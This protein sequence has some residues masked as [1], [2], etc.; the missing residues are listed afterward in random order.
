MLIDVLIA[1][2][3]AL[4]PRNEAE[5][6]AFENKKAFVSDMLDATNRG[7]QGEDVDGELWALCEDY[8]S[9][10]R[11]KAAVETFATLLNAFGALNEEVSALTTDCVEAITSAPRGSI[12]KTYSDEEYAK[13]ATEA[14]YT[15]CYA[16]YALC[17]LNRATAL[18]YE[19]LKNE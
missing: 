13:C 11:G 7:L 19:K 15:L 5:K 2:Q 6:K 3:S 4:T 9:S 1:K 18:A 16:D 14:L 10:V 8:V 17:K 12:T